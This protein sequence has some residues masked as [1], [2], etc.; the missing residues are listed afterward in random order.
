MPFYEF[1]I[2]TDTEIAAGGVNKGIQGQNRYQAFSRVT[3]RET[4]LTFCLSR[5]I[6]PK[7][8]RGHVMQAAG[9]AGPLPALSVVSGEFWVKTTLK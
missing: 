7:Q 8:R 6:G 2:C 1:F 5:E 3:K 4:Y 9:E